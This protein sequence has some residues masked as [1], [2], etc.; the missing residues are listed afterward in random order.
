MS[1]FV[2][3]RMKTLFRCVIDHPHLISIHARRMSNTIDAAA[4]TGAGKR[5]EDVHG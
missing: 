4:D 5:D 3:Q 1:R 2:S